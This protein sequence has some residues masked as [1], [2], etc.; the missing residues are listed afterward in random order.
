MPRRRLRRRA[1][2]TPRCRDRRRT[3]PGCTARSSC[4]WSLH[5][6]T[7]HTVKAARAITGE[8]IALAPKT[9]V[10]GLGTGPGDRVRRLLGADRCLPRSAGGARRQRRDVYLVE[11]A[12]AI[13]G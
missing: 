11:L 10:T 8:P 4:A 7:C 13:A 5:P 1:A 3:A 9:W 6:P 12:S 2:G